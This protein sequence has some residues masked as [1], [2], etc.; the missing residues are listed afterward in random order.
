M[1]RDRTLRWRRKG[2]FVDH[3]GAN[4]RYLPTSCRQLLAANVGSRPLICSSPHSMGLFPIK[5]QATV[6]A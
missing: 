3:Q 2:I 5:P 1:E 4:G 6:A